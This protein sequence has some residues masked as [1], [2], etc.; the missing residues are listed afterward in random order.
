MASN[1]DFINIL[2]EIRGSGIPGETAT[3]GIW[4]E[5]TIAD[6]DGN[7]GIYGDILA[8]YGIVTD[9]TD[10]LDQAVA[11]IDGLTVVANELAE[12]ESPTA[13]LVGT[14]LTLGIPVGNTGAT[15]LQGLQ[16]AKG[17]TGAKGE[18]GDK[19]DTGADGSNGHTP[20][21]AEV[22]AIV[23][24]NVNVQAAQ[25]LLDEAISDAESS[26]T[27]IL[28]DRE[29]E[30]DINAADRLTEY[31]ANHTEKLVEYNANDSEKLE[32]YNYNHVE[33]VMDLNDAYA[34]RIIEII[35]VGKF[36]GMMDTYTPQVETY[37]AEFLSTS[38]DTLVYLINGTIVDFANYTVLN[39]TQVEFDQ[40]IK[41]S[42]VVVQFDSLI[43]DATLAGTGLERMTNK[44]QPDGYAGLDESGLI[45]SELLPSYVD[46]VIEV[47][48]YTD[49]PIPGESSK[50]YVVIADETSGGNTSS[51]RWTGT[52]HA[53]VSNTL[54][55][56]DVKA[57]YESNTDTNAFTDDEKTKIA[58]ID[59]EL[60]TTSNVKFASVQFTG[61][62]GDEGT[63]SWNSNEGTLDLV[64]N[65]TTLQVGQET[66]IH[67]KNQSGSTIADG[68]VVMA[69]GTLGASGRVLI[70]PYDGVSL[71][72]YILGIAT[73]SIVNGSDGKV[74]N[75][76]K[77]RGLD[78]SAWSEGDELFVTIN[79]GLTNVEPSS[80][81]N[82]AIAYVINSH[83]NN[84]T[85]MVRFTPYDENLA[86]TKAEI[87]SAYGNVDNTAD[88]DK[89]VSDATQAALNGK[90]NNSQVLTNVPSNA[91]FTDT[92]YTHPTY[93]GDD[94]NVDTGTL[95][96][97]TVVSE[98]DFNVVTNTQ[99]HV[100][101]ANGVVS[102][103]TLTL[104]DLGYTGE[105][106]ANYFTYNH[107]STHPASMITTTDEFTYSDSDTVQDVLDDLDQAISNLSSNTAE[108][109]DRQL[110]IMN[111]KKR[112]NYKF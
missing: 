69:A 100:T 51:Y 19:G 74:T 16:G 76:G 104:A 111:M 108:E 59:Q 38:G 29:S 73:E 11:I 93:T 110:K 40:L 89:V 54:T 27:T 4:Y 50:L 17:A 10:T 48:T 107:P 87:D 66:Y 13:N 84:G 47:A 109:I 5:L 91:V 35:K 77:I 46:D 85:I 86:Y 72:K 33:R 97:A 37:V 26:L 63:L 60:S 21:E 22:D 31:D 99:G 43:L 9:K 92:V 23:S 98:I 81:I 44:N 30:F 56:T 80:G 90:V 70:A 65:S 75:F 49:L 67:A 71:P 103:R 42:D 83:V 79:G 34:K 95:T 39:E 24:T 45:S 6:I 61:G 53:M 78:T 12:G 62:T 36:A 105:T 7:P 58:D 102:T 88:V 106:D 2:R 14:T 82:V 3:D 57:M 94:I 68:T 20:T 25:T 64:A 32:E 28:T 55:T 101:D 15:G 1:A 52:V 41:I 96:G 8:K 112:L 18:K